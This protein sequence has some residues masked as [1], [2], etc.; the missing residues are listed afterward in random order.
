[1]R[2]R[3]AALVI[4]YIVLMSYCVKTNNQEIYLTQI[5]VIKRIEIYA[6]TKKCD[7]SNAYIDS[8]FPFRIGNI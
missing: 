6:L 7:L 3:K 4:T 5:L 2:K 1:M 8:Q